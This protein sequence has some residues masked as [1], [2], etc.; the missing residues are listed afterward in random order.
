M[1]KKLK[2]INVNEPDIYL[3]NIAQSIGFNTW[4]KSL[5]RSDLEIQAVFNPLG[6]STSEKVLE[7]F[8]QEKGRFRGSIAYLGEKAVGYSLV[9]E[10]HPKL[11]TQFIN[12]L[13]RKKS[14]VWLSEI[15][16]LP[17][18]Q[19]RGIGS[20]LLVE[21]LKD[22]SAKQKPIT[23]VLD[24]QKSTFRWFKKRGFY[25]EPNHF[26]QDDFYFG[27]TSK[28]VSEWRLEAESVAE[29]ISS[30]HKHHK[31]PNYLVDRQ[32]TLGDR[33]Q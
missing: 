1:E 23:F 6:P 32:K 3:T 29:V 2:I 28:P 26:H 7:I 18:Y 24:E 27:E 9:Q 33:D 25:P 30:I 15:N 14:D 5:N 13:L 22:F 11:R 4:R 16:V 31:L 12:K 20:S 17:N 10:D 19:K 21:S 8:K